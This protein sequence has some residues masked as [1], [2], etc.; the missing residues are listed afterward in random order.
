MIIKNKEEEKG[1]RKAAEIATHIIENASKHIKIGALPIEIDEFIGEECKK[2]KA[3]PSFKGVQMS[4]AS[5]YAYN[6]CIGVNDE[7]LHAIPSSDRKLQAGDIVKIDFGLI[8][9]GFY[10][11]QCFTFAIPPLSIGDIMLINTGKSAVENAVAQAIA[12]NKTGDLGYQMYNTATKAGFSVLL[13]YVGHGIGK[14][15]HEPPEIPAYGE[16]GKG[17]TL[18]KGMV[19]CVECQVVEGDGE[20]Y[21]EEN[22]W[23]IKTV[24]GGKGV[25]F[26]YMVIIGEKKPE[27]ITPMQNWKSVLS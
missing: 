4:G 21:I 25:M 6:S 16:K 5:P 26:E 3:R 7:V 9:N 15:L 14:S 12:G 11:D 20:T 1:I 24:N 19:V 8:Y 17:D 2:Y 13:D 23:T 18:K 27:I 10:T 22:G